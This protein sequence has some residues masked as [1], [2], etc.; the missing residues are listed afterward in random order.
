MFADRLTDRHGHVCGSRQQQGS[1]L[2]NASLAAVSTLLL[3]LSLSHPSHHPQVYHNLSSL[4]LA[5]RYCTQLLIES[6]AARGSLPA[7]CVHRAPELLVQFVEQLAG[8][9]KGN[10]V[11]S[12]GSIQTQIRLLHIRISLLVLLIPL[13]NLAISQE[14]G[15]SNLVAELVSH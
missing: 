8:R 2:A 3:S 7:E 4:R 15:D 1:S 6:A 14:V 5:L 13:R 10:K 12:V 11:Y 9:V